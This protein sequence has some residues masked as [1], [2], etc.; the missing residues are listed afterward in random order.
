MHSKSIWTS[1]NSIRSTYVHTVYDIPVKWCKYLQ[2]DTKLDFKGGEINGS[3]ILGI[4]Y[5]RNIQI[6][7][8]KEMRVMNINFNKQKVSAGYK[9]IYL[10]TDAIDKIEKI[11]NE[12]NT[13][14]N[15]VIVSLINNYLENK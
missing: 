8:W 9:T 2:W 3:K 11:A 12:N 15:N 7:T 13:S 14:F 5:K 4:P 10:K 1:C 6:S